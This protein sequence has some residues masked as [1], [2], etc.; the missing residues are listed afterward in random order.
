MIHHFFLKG[1][2]FIVYGNGTIHIKELESDLHNGIKST[3]IDQVL[4]DTPVVEGLNCEGSHIHK[5]GDYY[6]LMM[7]QW[8]SQVL[9]AGFNGVIIVKSFLAR[10]TGK[11]ILDDDMG[12]QNNGV[13]QG[14]AIQIQD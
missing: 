11:I 12:Y 13:A 2:V 6:Y 9:D 7:I 3:V 5:V 8:P 14:V 4:L 10:Y 1:R